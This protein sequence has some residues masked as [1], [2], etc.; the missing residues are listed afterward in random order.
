MKTKLSPCPSMMTSEPGDRPLRRARAR[1]DD[2]RRRAHGLGLDAHAS[3]LPLLRARVRGEG[4]R[5]EGEQRGCQDSFLTHDSH[6]LLLKFK[7]DLASNHSANGTRPSNEA[8]A[9]SMFD[10]AATQRTKRMARATPSWPRST[11]ALTRPPERSA[12]NGSPKRSSAVRG[13]STRTTWAPSPAA[14]P[15]PCASGM[16]SVVISAR[17]PE[18]AAAFGWC[19]RRSSH[20]R[21]RRTSRSSSS[22]RRAARAAGGRWPSSPALYQPTRPAP[23]RSTCLRRARR[24]GR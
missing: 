21:R 11:S 7:P 9:I 19:R 18:A 22:H 20:R 17:S 15:P 10:V 12:L 16:N 23:S 14:N 24:A 13:S 2:T 3:R 4:R 8:R 1:D 6:S 5:R